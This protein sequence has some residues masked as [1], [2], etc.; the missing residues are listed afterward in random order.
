MIVA[1]TT[2]P[3]S[4]KC[5]SMPSLRPRSTGFLRAG[6]ALVD[7]TCSSFSSTFV[8]SLIFFSDGLF[9]ELDLDVDARLK[10]Q[11][12]EGVDRLL[13]WIVDVD[14][15]LVR[16]NL[17]LLARVLVDEGTLDDRELLDACRQRDRTGDRRPRP[18]RGLDD[19]RRGLVDELVV[20]RLEPDPDALL[21]HRYAPCSISRLRGRGP[22]ARSDRGDKLKAVRIR[23]SSAGAGA[24]G[25]GAP[26]R[27]A[28]RV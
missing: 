7:S 4:L 20:V 28:E 14:E 5:W 22:W 25:A 2:E 17:E 24:Q 16:A 3:S 19:L 1:P 27:E 11:L 12:H 15:P 23:S 9:L 6:A 18:L 13:R 21:C 26:G 8:S 10:V